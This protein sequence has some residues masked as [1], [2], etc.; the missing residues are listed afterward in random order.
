MTNFSRKTTWLA[1]KERAVSCTFV[2]FL[3]INKKT[4]VGKLPECSRK[5][6]DY[7]GQVIFFKYE[8]DQSEFL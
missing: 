8:M 3:T 6:S 1:T 5:I 2:I 7:T 4:S